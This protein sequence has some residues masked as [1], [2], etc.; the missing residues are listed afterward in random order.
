MP[1]RRA[2]VLRLPVLR[3]QRQVAAGVEDFAFLISKAEKLQRQ[4]KFDEAVAAYI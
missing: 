2:N 4:G 1:S 3:P